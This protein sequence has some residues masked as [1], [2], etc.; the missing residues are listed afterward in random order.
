MKLG[1][2]VTK[3][4]QLRDERGVERDSPTLKESI[5]SQHTK[6]I[7]VQVWSNG[8]VRLQVKKNEPRANRLMDTPLRGPD[9]PLALN[10]FFQII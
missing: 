10:V 8:K 1:L 7:T 3:C 2:T 6:R 4:L 9:P 5:I